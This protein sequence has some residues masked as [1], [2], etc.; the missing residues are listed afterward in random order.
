M[1]RWN[2]SDPGR[3]AKEFKYQLHPKLRGIILELE[4][5]CH[6]ALKKDTEVISICRTMDEEREIKGDP[7]EGKHQW[8]E[9]VLVIDLM[10]LYGDE[11]LTAIKEHLAKCGARFVPLVRKDKRGEY[12]HVEVA[13]PGGI[14]R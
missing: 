5:F 3:I 12:L 10:N 2:Q 7:V 11:E 6:R 13:L 4:G 1:L 8:T 9:D 14:E